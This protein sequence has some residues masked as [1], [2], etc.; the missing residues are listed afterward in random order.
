MRTPDPAQL[1]NQCEIFNSRYPIGTKVAVRKDDGEAFITKTRSKADV[2]SGHTAAIWLE[3]L[4]GCSVLDRVSPI[5]SQGC[6]KPPKLPRMDRDLLGKIIDDVFDGAIEDA[7]VI[8][9]IY[10]SIARH[11]SLPLSGQEGGTGATHRHRKRGTEYVLLGVGRMQTERWE[12]VT[13]RNQVTSVDM[14]EVAIYRSIEDG[15]LW[16]RPREEFEDGRFEAISTC[17]HDWFDCSNAA[18]PPPAK[19]CRKCGWTC[20]DDESRG[21]FIVW[22]W[23]QNS[24]GEIGGGHG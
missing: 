5:K 21:V 6:G 9:D 22:P 18:G 7:S 14:R 16:A 1:R 3:G 8:E 23:L 10:A 24:H 20:G 11:A 15:S 13:Y 12:D 4:T 19:S 2:I 17:V